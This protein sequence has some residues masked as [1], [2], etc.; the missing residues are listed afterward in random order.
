MIAEFAEFSHTKIF[1]YKVVYIQAFSTKKE[2]TRDAASPFSVS[3]S[4]GPLRPVPAKCVVNSPIHNLVGADGV[5]DKFSGSSVSQ[6]HLGQIYNGSVTAF[7]RPGTGICVH[8]RTAWNAPEPIE[9]R[10]ELASHRVGICFVRRKFCAKRENSRPFDSRPL[11][12]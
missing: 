3:S 10:K 4:G 8:A 9:F 1:V 2:R 12:P 6:R 5:L 7:P 11:R